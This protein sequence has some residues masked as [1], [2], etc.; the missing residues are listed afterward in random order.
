MCNVR[1]E[2]VTNE[3][4]E[5]FEIYWWEENTK[6]RD[7]INFQNLATLKRNPIFSPKSIENAEYNFQ[8]TVVDTNTHAYMLLGDSEVRRKN[9][10]DFIRMIGLQSDTHS[11]VDMIETKRIPF[12]DY[13]TIDKLIK[14]GTVHP[15]RRIR[16]R[17]W[18]K[19]Y[20]CNLEHSKLLEK[21]LASNYSYAFVFEDD[22]S[23]GAFSEAEAQIQ[24]TDLISM[25]PSLWDVQYHGFCWTQYSPFDVNTKQP[26]NVNPNKT[27]YVRT[28]FPMCR[29]AILFNRVAARVFVNNWK[30]FRGGGD[31]LLSEMACIFGLKIVRPLFPLFEQDRTLTKSSLANIGWLYPFIYKH[32]IKREVQ[33]LKIFNQSKADEYGVTGGPPPPNRSQISA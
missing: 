17:H 11:Y 31:A 22:V 29:H 9:A 23:L 6:K 33:C 4:R 16:G 27:L 1:A 25:D 7:K 5:D 2:R 8:K 20:L 10:N 21:F 18:A 14:N 28:L 15:D 24:M 32:D 19:R 12:L 3:T 26:I 30:P 13:K